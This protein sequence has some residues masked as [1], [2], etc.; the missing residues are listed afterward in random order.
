MTALAVFLYIAI[1]WQLSSNSGATVFN[2]DFRVFWAAARLAIEGHPLDAFDVTRLAEVQDFPAD[3]WMPW[4]YPPG[5]LLLLLPLGLLSFFAAWAVYTG[6]SAAAMLA[7]LRPFLRGTPALWIGVALSPAAL[8]TLLLGQ[9]SLLWVAGLVAALAALR[10]N[11]P[12]LAG[13][14]LGLLTVKPQLG[15]LIPVALIAAGQWRTIGAAA[16]TSLALTGVATALFGPDYWPAWHDIAARHLDVLRTEVAGSPRMVSLYSLLSSLGLTEPLALAVQGAVT[17]VAAVAVWVG[18]LRPALS[19]DL[20][21]ALLLTAIPLSTPY[22]W[23]NE[24]VFLAPALLFLI[25]SGA[26][27]LTPPG[28]AFAALC[29]L[30]LGPLTLARILGVDNLPSPRLIAVPLAVA[31]F[32]LAVRALLARR[33]T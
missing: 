6:L 11:R 24:T 20:R 8:V 28:L 3:D 22:L 27:P 25:R 7:A 15:L 19:F 14:F 23:H 1:T 16:L 4:V 31:A 18:W 17:L 2:V 21:A 9:I 5:F 26:L 33:P 12:W 10:G 13:L 32:A 30:G 29:W